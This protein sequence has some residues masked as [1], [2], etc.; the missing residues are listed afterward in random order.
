MNCSKV[1]PKTLHNYRTI[2]PSLHFDRGWPGLGT[3]G[4]G[5]DPSVGEPREGVSYQIHSRRLLIP[6]EL[7]DPESSA[8]PQVT[9]PNW[10][11]TLDPLWRLPVW[12]V[13]P[14]N[15]EPIATI[16]FTEI[17]KG[18]SKCVESRDVCVCVFR[19]SETGNRGCGPPIEGYFG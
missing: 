9:S 11:R 12:S 5:V 18:N 13:V 7:A 14:V 3:P 4:W 6:M 17:S 1:V 16:V 19:R 15:G 8:I 2:M 10:S